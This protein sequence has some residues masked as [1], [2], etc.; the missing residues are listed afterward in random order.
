MTTYN[1]D[2][3]QY[4]TGRALE[5]SGTM[6][7]SEIATVLSDETELDISRNV[8]HG[9]IYRN[10]SVSK[11][12]DK[13]HLIM[14][15]FSKYADYYNGK[16]SPVEKVDYDYSSGPLKILVLNDLHVPFQ[17]EAALEQALSNNRS[18]DIVI[19]SEVADMYSLTSFAKYQHV[20]FDFEVEEIIRWFEF[21][22]ENFPATYVL[23]AGHDRRLSRYVLSRIRSDLLF[24][25]ETDLLDLLARPFSNVV[26]VPDIKYSINDAIFTHFDISSSIP[27]RSAIRAHEWLRE[28]KEHF[29]IP[30]YKLLVQAHTHKSGIINLPGVQLVESGC[31]QTVPEWVFRKFPTQS[32]VH[33]YCVVFQNDGTT[34]LDG[35]RVCVYREK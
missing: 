21:L 12:G 7:E 20:P 25:V 5:L 9:R 19:T 15:Y 35:T 34:N 33:G 30:P 2:I 8:V 16:L 14:P 6:S 32:W 1:R 24:L 10:K 31:F 18:A 28:W 23:H 3:D 11:L 4:I 26:V 13:P 27:M 17:H 22:N 29:D